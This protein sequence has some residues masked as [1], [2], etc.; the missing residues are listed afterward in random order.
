[1]MALSVL[2]VLAALA[3][4]LVTLDLLDRPVCKVLLVLKEQLELK[5]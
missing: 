4:L 3:A 2:L 1:M 5:E